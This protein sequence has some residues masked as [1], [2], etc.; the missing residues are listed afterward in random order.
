MKKTTII[1]MMLLLFTAMA[2][3]QKKTIRVATDNLDLVMQV[4]P[5]GRLYQ[6]YLGKPLIDAAD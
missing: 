1:A 5:N 6:V 4:A 3:A 2:S